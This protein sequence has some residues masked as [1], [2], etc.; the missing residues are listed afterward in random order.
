MVEVN[1]ERTEAEIE[2]EILKAHSEIAMNEAQ[3]RL[4]TAEAIEAERKGQIAQ[5]AVENET[6]TLHRNQISYENF[7]HARDK[8][9]ASDERH[10]VYYFKGEVTDVS[11]RKC[12]E[13]LN[14][15]TRI[16]EGKNETTAIEIIINSEGGDIVDGL[17]LFD[18]I[19]I[20]RR[21]GHHFTTTAIGMAAS[22]GGI[23]LQA[24]DKRTMGKE[25][26]MLIHE[27]SFGVSGSMGKVEDRMDLLKK[28]Q[29]RLCNILADQS[30]LTV[31]EIKLKWE[32][33]DWWL[34]SDEALELGFVD[35]VR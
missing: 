2:V 28:L 6:M 9:H 23:L 1:I 31:E 4:F 27:A 16:A 25:S 3:A 13:Q 12:F 5:L 7:L 17:A 15:W 8:D 29:D 33:K 24:G 35:E 30:A 20:A 10:H 11:V 26:I 34:T 18:Y 32:R 19:Q 21:K 22:M 14:E